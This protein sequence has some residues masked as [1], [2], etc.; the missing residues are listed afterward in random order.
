MHDFTTPSSDLDYRMPADIRMLPIMDINPNDKSCIYSTLRFLEAQANLLGMPT[1]CVTF[2]QPLWLKA[3]EIVLNEKMNVVCR[4]GAFHTV[5]NFLGAIGSIMSGSGLAESWQVC[6]GPVSMTHML[7]GKAYAKALRGHLLVESALSSLLLHAVLHGTN[8]EVVIQLEAFDPCE[9]SLLHEYYESVISRTTDVVEASVPAI[10][11]KLDDRLSAYKADLAAV[12]RTAKLWLQY[13]HY[14]NVAKNFIRAER[15][16]DWN[17]HL[18]SLT[19]MLNLFAAAGHRNYAKCGR[20]YVEQ[21][22]RLPAT[23]PWLF[24]R[25]NSD[26]CHSVRRSDRYWTGLSTDLIIEQVMMRNVKSRGGLTH[27][28]G[29]NKN[30]RHL[31]VCS[32]HKCAAVHAASLTNQDRSADVAAHV[33]P[34]RI[35]HG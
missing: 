8:N 7:T 35:S 14:V 5:M 21:M 4:L 9:I 30:V 16:N 27:G 1:A 22:Q 29:M 20:L 6:Y 32:M 34:F 23:H 19:Q 24:E 12:S 28:R 10:I 17:L 26:Q 33:V 15:T 31:W 18:I 3:A 25:L 11:Q 13:L 2:D